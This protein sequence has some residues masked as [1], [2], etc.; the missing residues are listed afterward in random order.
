MVVGKPPCWMDRKPANDNWRPELLVPL[1]PIKSGRSTLCRF[2]GHLTG[3]DSVSDRALWAAA[4]EDYLNALKIA[5]KA[6]S[7]EPPPYGTIP[8][9]ETIQA[10]AATVL[11]HFTRLRSEPH[12][13]V[14]VPPSAAVP[15]ETKAAPQSGAVPPQCPKCGGK[16]WDNREGK[17]NPKSPDWKCRDKTCVDDKGFVTA[18]WIEKPKGGANSRPAPTTSYDEPPRALVPDGDDDLPF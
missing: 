16:V 12:V 3:G 5:V 14:Q 4:Q 2:V 6:W 18:G 8:T 13:R 7:T 10:A 9:P 1:T 17:K 11:I 15:A